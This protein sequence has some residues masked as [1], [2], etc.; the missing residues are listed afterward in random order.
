MDMCR[1]GIQS[2]LVKGCCAWSCQVKGEEEN[3]RRS[4]K[5]HASGW[6]VRQGYG[7]QEELET[8][9]PLWQPLMGAAERKR[10]N[11]YLYL[12]GVHG[13]IA[14]FIKIRRMSSTLC[15]RTYVYVQTASC[16]RTSLKTLQC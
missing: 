3:Q 14:N 10:R 11:M 13:I 4:K 6:S 2:I 1:N 16:E 15:T 7:E 8:A 12:L 9:N 5:R